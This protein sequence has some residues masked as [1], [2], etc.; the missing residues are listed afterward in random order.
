MA[1]SYLNRL[2][3]CLMGCTQASKGLDAFRWF[4]NL[5]ALS[6]ELITEMTDTELKS[7]TMFISR[8]NQSVLNSKAGSIPNQLYMEL[9][10]E[11]SKLRTILKKAGLLT[12]IKEEMDETPEGWDDDD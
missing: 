5:C 9:H 12:K 7:N 11:E 10:N 8:I 3:E 4:H 2:N 1:M 6:R